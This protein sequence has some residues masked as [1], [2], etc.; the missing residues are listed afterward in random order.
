MRDLSVSSSEAGECLGT[1]SEEAMQDLASEL[2]LKSLPSL[3]EWVATSSGAP[4]LVDQTIEQLG[5]PEPTY[6][7]DGT[8]VPGSVLR[9]L[10]YWSHVEQIARRLRLRHGGEQRRSA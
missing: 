4:S 7:S 6:Y 10:L 2:A 3:L 8:P 1:L 5:V 9:K